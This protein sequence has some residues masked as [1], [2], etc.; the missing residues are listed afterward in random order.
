MIL[1]FVYYH[2]LSPLH[3]LLHLIQALVIS[4]F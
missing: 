1:A 3:A 2:V 4:A